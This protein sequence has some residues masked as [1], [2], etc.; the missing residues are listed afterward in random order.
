MTILARRPAHMSRLKWDS[1]RKKL[2]TESRRAAFVVNALEQNGPIDFPVSATDA[3]ALYASSRLIKRTTFFLDELSVVGSKKVGKIKTQDISEDDHADKNIIAARLERDLRKRVIDVCINYILDIPGANLDACDVLWRMYE[4]LQLA[5]EGHRT[6]AFTPA[7]DKSPGTGDSE[8]H[9]CR[10]AAVAAAQS[11]YMAFGLTQMQ[12]I[13]KIMPRVIAVGPGHFG[14]QLAR[15][16]TESTIDG[17]RGD[18]LK[19]RTKCA[20]AVRRDGVWRAHIGKMRKESPEQLPVF[21]ERILSAALQHVLLESE[22]EISENLK[23]LSLE[24]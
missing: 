18:L 14:Y 12:A 7:K 4:D 16:L 11:A 10:K 20:E 8:R 17:W 24:R 9:A 5:D 19:G 13:E 6:P 23:N 3:T 22:K 1:E 15:E 21:A 2:L